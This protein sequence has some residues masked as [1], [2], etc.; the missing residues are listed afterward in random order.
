MAEINVLSDLA[1]NGSLI[2]TKDNADFPENPAIGTLVLKEQV[3]YAYIA[4]GG[5]STWYPFS[6]KTN[7]YI[8]TQGLESSSWLINH[9]LGTADVWYQ[10]H[11]IYGNIMMQSGITPVDAN[12]FYINFSTPVEGTAIIVSPQDVEAST[13]KTSLINVANDTVVIDSTGIKIDGEY[14]VA[15]ASGISQEEFNAEI[16]ARIAADLSI[17]ATID[18]LGGPTT[19]YAVNL[20]AGSNIDLSNGKYVSYF[21]NENNKQVIVTKISDLLCG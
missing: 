10:V 13:I 16:T 21:V 3:L 19:Q 15:G 17:Q 8:H 4:I 9:G 18:S 20:A 11:D 1:L 6:T 2:M 12:S 7:S 14:L 5:L